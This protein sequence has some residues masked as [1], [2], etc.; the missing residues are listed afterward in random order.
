[1]QPPPT[2]PDPATFDRFLQRQG[3]LLRARD[4]APGGRAAW[5]RR[6]AELRAALLK[7]IGPMP[8]RPGPLEPKVLGEIKRDGYRIEK[9][10]FQSQPGVWVTANAYVPEPL[11]AK[12]VPAVLAVH[13]HWP[14]ARR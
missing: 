7:A 8:D 11:P 3:Q 4:E 13:G 14:W 12:A 6:R 5:D 9:L 1:M 2:A 10:I